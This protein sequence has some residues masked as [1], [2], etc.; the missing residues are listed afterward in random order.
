MSRLSFDTAEVL[1]YDP[2]SANRNASRAALY[3]IGFRRI[4]TVATIDAFVESVRRRPP[5]L[6]LCEAQGFETEL[7][8][9]VQSLRQGVTTYNP[10]II[11]IVTAWEQTG[12]LVTRPELR[13]RRSLTSVFRR[14]SP[15]ASA[16]ISNGEK[17]LSSPPTTSARTAAA[18]T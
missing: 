2:V 14:R 12:A 5:D 3:T 8:D 18:M 1:V 15:R 4:E 11:I 7:C 6:T 13:R 9:T 17:A 16:V 10:F